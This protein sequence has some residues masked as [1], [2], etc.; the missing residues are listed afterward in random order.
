M[1]DFVFSNY[2]SEAFILCRLL[3]GRSGCSQESA[4][5]VAGSGWAVPWGQGEKPHH[6]V[7]E[8]LWV[9][10]FGDGQCRLGSIGSSLQEAANHAGCI[11]WCAYDRCHEREEREQAMAEK[12]MQ[13][14]NLG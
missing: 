8:N 6:F 4:M 3:E 5:W 2:A 10:L 9:D 11:Q 12:S 1:V 14:D 13:V 7:R